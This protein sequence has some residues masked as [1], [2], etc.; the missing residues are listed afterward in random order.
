MPEQNSQPIKS[1][2]QHFP[3]IQYRADKSNGDWGLAHGE[4]FRAGIQELISIRKELML[5]K[6]PRLRPQLNSLAMAQFQ[7]TLDF[8]PHLALEL[9][10]IANGAGVSL[11]DIVIL[12]NYTDFRDIIL[13]DEGCS[14]V[15][16][17]K[18]NRAI[19]GQTWD[20]H[21]SAK[22]YLC[23][24][25]LPSNKNHSQTI[26]LSLVGCLGL[27]GLTSKGLFIGVNNINTKN[28]K[29]GLIWPALVRSTLE[30][31]SLDEMSKRLLKA[32]VTSGH[33]YLISD[34]TSGQHY[35]ISPTAKECVSQVK[36][37]QTQAFV[38]HTN[39]C[40]GQRNK[41][42]EENTSLS[43][44]TFDRYTLLEKNLSKVENAYQLLGLLTSH[45]NY[46]K[47]ICS[48]FQSGVLDP[49][50]TCGGGAYDYQSKTL[51]TWRGCPVHDINFS[52]RVF[53]M[54][55]LAST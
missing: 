25:A 17:K 4:E 18:E 6:N 38:F 41:E 24:I 16:L 19:V 21:S 31:Q 29:A 50:S 15:F 45:E 40:L 43:S 36:A 55:N 26:I 51:F 44:T 11:E 14:T 5:Q 27:M 48:H 35:E 8:S 12:N 28:A 20:M 42:V 13:P 32:P 34:S 49:S 30:A 23:T 46:P 39:H 33:N 37:S 9:E 3:H 10:G 52:Q 53:N 54:D 22:N 2:D 7:T 1:T 47:S